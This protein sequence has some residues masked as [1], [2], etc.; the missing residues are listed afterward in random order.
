MLGKT[1]AAIKAI[2][3]MPEGVIS[4]VDVTEEMIRRFIEKAVGR[5]PALEC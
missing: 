5:R 2:R 3:P 4:D 1:P